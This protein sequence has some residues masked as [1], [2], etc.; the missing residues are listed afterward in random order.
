MKKFKKGSVESFKQ[1]WVNRP[2]TNYNHFTR[3]NPKNQI[4]FE[5]KISM[6]EGL[7]R[8][9]EWYESKFSS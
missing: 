7:K 5:P 2:E 3:D 4:Q 1:N 6:D 8:T 9:V